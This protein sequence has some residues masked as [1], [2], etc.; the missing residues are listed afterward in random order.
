MIDTKNIEETPLPDRAKE[1]LTNLGY[2]IS[3]KVLQLKARLIFNA[4]YPDRDR[5]TANDFSLAHNDSINYIDTNIILLSSSSYIKILKDSIFD[6]INNVPKA[7]LEDNNSYFEKYIFTNQ[8]LDNEK[9]NHLGISNLDELGDMFTIDSIG[10]YRPSISNILPIKI[11]LHGMMQ[12]TKPTI[13]DHYLWFYIDKNFAMKLPERYRTP[14]LRELE[15]MEQ[16]KRGELPPE[17]ACEALK[18][19]KSYLGICTANNPEIKNL[20]VYPNPV[21]EKTIHVKFSLDKKTKLTIALYKPNGEFVDNLNDANRE[22]NA[23]NYWLTFQKPNLE[24]GVYMLSIADD[25]G[26]RAIRKI[27]VQN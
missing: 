17:M 9:V 16:I 19:E 3:P 24:N 22:Y 8:Y 25:N 15:I 12:G 2:D 27:I 23:D 20:Q 5:I 1:M 14:I 21:T 26:N 7:V 11:T 18:G 10:K 4:N 6:N 13:T